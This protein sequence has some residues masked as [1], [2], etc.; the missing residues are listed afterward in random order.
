MAQWGSHERRKAAVAHRIQ[1][2]TLELSSIDGHD[3]VTAEQIVDRADVSP[4]T[5]YRYSRTKEGLMLQ[6][7]HDNPLTS[8]TA[9]APADSARLLDAL[10]EVVRATVEEHFVRDRQV[11]VRR[12]RLY[13]EIPVLRSVAST[14]IARLIDRFAQILKDNGKVDYTDDLIAPSAVILG[15]LA[16]AWGWYR[17]GAERFFTVYADAV[18]NVLAEKLTTI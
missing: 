9:D 18:V 10:R 8:M 1:L 17:E 16:T 2:A 15:L 14:S 11:T 12:I 6:D 5:T 3:N 13:F 7:E 4:S